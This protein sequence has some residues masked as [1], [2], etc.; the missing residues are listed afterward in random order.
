M[1]FN[2]HQLKMKNKF[3]IILINQP[4]QFLKQERKIHND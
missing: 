1:N 2:K 3:K 4:K